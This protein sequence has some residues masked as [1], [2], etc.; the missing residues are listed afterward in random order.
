MVK[1]F[2]EKDGESEK[3]CVESTMI[4]ENWRICMLYSRLLCGDLIPGLKSLL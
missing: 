4:G 2:I 3:K 1:L